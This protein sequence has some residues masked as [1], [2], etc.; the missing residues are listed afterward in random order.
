MNVPVYE[1]EVHALALYLWEIDGSLD[2]RAQEYRE[3]ARTRLAGA[4]MLS[5]LQLPPAAV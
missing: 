5:G 3:K 2:G 1:E 4:G